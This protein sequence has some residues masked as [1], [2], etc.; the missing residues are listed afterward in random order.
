MAN[1]PEHKTIPIFSGEFRH[2]LDEKNR[3][4]IP[5]CWRNGEAAEF[6]IVPNPGKPCLTAMPSEVFLEAGKQIAAQSG[7]SPERHRIF[8]GQ[9]YSRAKTLIA[10]KQGRMLLP[11]DFCKRAGLKN[12]AV[13][14][15]GRDRFDIWSPSGWAKE[16][17]SSESTFK[18]VWRLAGL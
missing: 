9:F 14:S 4:T 10:D 3:I 16:I 15:G 13:L 12:E 7:I 5:S 17:E 11:E 2:A 8:I 6:F 1:T 18:E